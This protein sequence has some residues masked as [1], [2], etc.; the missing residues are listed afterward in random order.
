MS[1]SVRADGPSHH[2]GFDPAEP[3]QQDRRTEAGG[4][5]EGRRIGHPAYGPE[6]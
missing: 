1:L 4:P 3:S 6:R 2:A 5:S